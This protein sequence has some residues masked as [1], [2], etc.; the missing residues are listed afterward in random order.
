MKN[1][2][3]PSLPSAPSSSGALRLRAVFA[4]IHRLWARR[5]G[6]D[7]R[8]AIARMGHCH[9]GIAAPAQ[10][11]AA[12]LTVLMLVAVIAII[13]AVVLE[14]LTLSTRLAANAGA[15]D[16]S[17]AYADS[18]SLLIERRLTRIMEQNPARMTVAQGWLGQPQ[19][20]AVPGGT[21]TA[22]VRD[23]GNCFNLN[24]LVSGRE[25]GTIMRDPIAI[26]QFSALM[27]ALGIRPAEAQQ[28][29]A[30]T[31]DWIDSDSVPAPGGAED[32]SYVSRTPAY[33]PANQLM[34]DASEL[35]V[36]AGVSARLYTLVRPWI[37]ALPTTDLS[38]INVNTLLPQQA[39]LIAM[40]APGKLPVES[41]RMMIIQRP[42]D[43][44][45]SIP[46]FWATPA[47]RGISPP[48]QASEQVRLTT[49]WFRVELNVQLG[50]TVMR[51]WRLY[52]ARMAP[53][54]LV[55][56]SWGEEG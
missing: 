20:V 29:A 50:E 37:C 34:A 33:R 35:R 11:G 6:G 30:A 24:S 47:L 23:G 36:V 55:R 49:T 45:D 2:F 15:L 22:M 32:E 26:A 56:A 13:S 53:V 41:A 46:A 43:G 3:P 31:A 51:Q 16:Q 10:Q 18:A 25:G 17:R 28:V 9:G 1:P 54:R 21:V 48:A 44:Y 5:A 19:G 38:P 4:A 14:R 7:R 12:L 8:H 39:P 40:L 27:Q 42:V 52:D